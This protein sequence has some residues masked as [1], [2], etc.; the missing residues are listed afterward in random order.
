[1]KKILYLF[2]ILIFMC[3]NV[4]YA[5]VVKITDKNLNSALQKIV[6]SSENKEGYIISVANKVITI[7]VDNESYTINY[8]LTD[9]PTFSLEVPIQKGMN[10]DDFK[11]KTGN[12]ILPMLGYIAVA[13]IQGVEIKDANAYFLFSYLGSALN[14]S[15]LTQS[16]Y[17]IVD[18]LKLEEGVTI[19]KTDDPKTIY[20]SEFGERVMEYVNN[21]YKEKQ[22]ISDST[23][24]N[25]YTL[26]IEKIETT[27]TSCKLVSKLIVNPDANFS[28]IIG[29]TDKMENSFM[30]KDI[31]KE[32][33][34]YTLT[35]K[36]GQ[37]CKIES[38]KKINGH[39]FYS[40]DCIKIND[41]H[42]EITAIKVGETNGYFYIGNVKK[43]IY[44]TVEENTDNSPLETL[45]LKIN[46]VANKTS[47]K[48]NS[49][50][51]TQT[52]NKIDIDTLP[53]TGEEI[54]VLL[55]VLYI[56]VGIC[57][58]ALVTLVIMKKRKN[59]H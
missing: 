30:N 12:L 37:K 53:R 33:A 54:N 20:T 22:S 39:E 11:E 51:Q 50:T 42:T 2:F 24:I 52:E 14:G 49:Q 8:D 19:E 38:D 31:T 43:S 29:Y 7:T 17:T 32:N 55:I 21:M 59:N 13:N 23:G 34:D 47:D 56:V 40:S 18:D 10:Y 6:S 26:D 4:C 44:I 28:K 45:T 3:T 15:F 9:K 41:D 58:V 5:T 25:S 46:S 16:S 27:E 57:S 36:V 48:N 1:M 35:L